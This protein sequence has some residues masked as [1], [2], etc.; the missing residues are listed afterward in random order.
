MK[1]QA[2][3]TFSQPRQTVWDALMDFDLLGRT[4]PGVQ[5]MTPVTPEKCEM[6]L[7]VLV[8]AITGRY[9][10]EVEVVEKSPTDSYRLLGKANGRL[11]WVRGEAKFQ[12]A[13][14]N[15]GTR[16]D[17]EMD[18][19]TGGLLSS[20]GARFMEAVGKGMLRDF[21]QNFEKELV[22]VKSVSSGRNSVESIAESPVETEPDTM[23]RPDDARTVPR[24]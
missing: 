21:F 9:T 10:G 17:A 3:S 13:D 15:G 2:S 14:E 11:G 6:D 24:T 16:V 12:L 1:V 19:A 7:K 8:P 4:L 5:R 20:V 23:I 22:S 18:F